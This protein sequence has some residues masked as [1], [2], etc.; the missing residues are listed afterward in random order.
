MP[1]GK[2]NKRPYRT[3][4][5][6]NKHKLAVQH[7]QSMGQSNTH[8]HKQDGAVVRTSIMTSSQDRKVLWRSLQQAPLLSEHPS[9]GA[10]LH[11]REAC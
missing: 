7:G 4:G 9:F 11:K 10:L 3:Q 1:S 6:M 2:W 8:P 5:E